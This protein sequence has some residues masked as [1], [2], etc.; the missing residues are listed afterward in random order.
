MPPA[1]A[2]SCRKD[3]RGIFIANV[4]TK[5]SFKTGSE[6]ADLHDWVRAWLPIVPILV[7]AQRCAAA[8][9]AALVIDDE[10]EGEIL[11]K[12]R[13]TL[14]H[15]LPV[16]RVQ[17]GMTGAVCRCTASPHR[18]SLAIVRI[19]TAEGTLIIFPSSAR[20]NGMP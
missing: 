9:A 20:E 3:L 4:L 13:G 14:A 10:V 6:C 16:E 11:D 19:V 1:P 18:R 15:R 5:N 12:E 2:A 17:H 7:L 8:V